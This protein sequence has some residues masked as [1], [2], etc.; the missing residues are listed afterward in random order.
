MTEEDVLN[1]IKKDNWMIHALIIAER[2]NLK[3]WFIGAGFV[4]NKVWDYL[5]GYSDLQKNKTDIDLV[6]YDR[7][8]NNEEEDRQ[9]SDE[10][11]KETGMEWE[12]VNEVY[13][14]T[15]NNIAPYQSVED[16]ISQWPE[17]ATAI[18]V[19]LENGKLVLMAPYGINDMVNLTVRK[20][21]KFLGNIDVVK[22]E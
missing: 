6:Y 8:G 21:P 16:A 18:G 15:F 5:H 20:S 3:N 22:K 13:A 14:H 19:K 7:E 17:T 10:L 12:V 2:Q 4:R 11:I 9:L 1:L